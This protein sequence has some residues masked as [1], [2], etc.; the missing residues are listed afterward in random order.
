[1]PVKCDE[2]SGVCVMAIDGD[3]TEDAGAQVKRFAEQRMNNRKIVDFVLDLGNTAFVNSQGLETLLW[4]KRR[5]DEHLG[6]VKIAG[7]DQNCRKIFEITRL[8]HRFE[9]HADVQSA[10]KT[11]R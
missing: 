5:C 6:R 7:M 1:M 10:M 11:F 2:Y 8:V 9:C 4:L 3:F